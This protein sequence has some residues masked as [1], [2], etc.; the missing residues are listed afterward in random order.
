MR[1]FPIEKSADILLQIARQF[2]GH[3]RSYLEAFGTGCEGKE[4]QM[5]ELVK[6]LGGAKPPAD[7]PES[8]AWITWRLGAPAAVS[9]IKERA[10]SANLFVPQRKLMVDALAFVKSPYAALAMVD[11]AATPDFPLKAEAS[12]W[13]FNRK[14]NLWENYGID[15]A[16][17]EKGL[18][19][20][21][22]ITLSSVVSPDPPAEPSKL[23]PIPEILKLEGNAERGQAAVAVCYTCHKIGSQGTDVGPDL[24]MFGKTQTREVILIS[25]INP[26]AEIAHGYEASRVLTKDKVQ[27]DGIVLSKA[28]PVMVRSMGGITQM[29]PRKRVKSITPLDR[30]LM[31]SADMLGLSEQTL[32]DIAAY[33]QSDKIK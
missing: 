5:F 33:L 6:E 23:A 22:T 26:S 16:M 3:D 31:L 15:D 17:K 32:A 20:P 21:D 2:D 14:G 19:D 7:W 24:T 9:A 25:I 10:L 1:D 4:R 29:V 18:Y 12:W 27:I 8:L 30:S 13:L 28:D 11:L